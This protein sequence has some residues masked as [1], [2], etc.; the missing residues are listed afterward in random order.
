MRENV[1]K[2]R[3][4]SGEPVYGVLTPIYDP[5]VAEVVGR[6]GFDLYMV[7]CEHGAGG[8]VQVEHAV[9]AC[10]TVGITPLARV[11]STDPKLIL[12]FLDV[13]VMGVMMPG[14]RDAD[15]VKRLVEAVKYAPMGRRGIAAVRA[16]DYLL[17]AAMPQDQYVRFSNEQTLVLPQIE[18]MEAVE[19]LDSLLRVEGVD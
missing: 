5:A 18:L 14:I 8:P 7:D 6:L 13:G 10:E 9:R 17:G 19:S 3:L 4:E 16:N 2:T 12:Q 11:R 15:D 1:L